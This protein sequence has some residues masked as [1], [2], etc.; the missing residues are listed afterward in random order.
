MASS[1]Y[2]AARPEILGQETRSFE[3]EFNL[4]YA[5]VWTAPQAGIHIKMKQFLIKKAHQ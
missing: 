3:I 1:R 5:V 4:I 2:K